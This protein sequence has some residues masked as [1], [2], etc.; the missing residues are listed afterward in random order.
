MSEAAAE[1]T[2]SME[3][4]LEAAFDEVEDGDGEVSEKGGGS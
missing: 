3:E 4:D 1:E 2:T